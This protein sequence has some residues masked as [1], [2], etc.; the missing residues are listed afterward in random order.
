[1]R[2]QWRMESSENSFKAGAREEVLACGAAVF[3]LM[4][5]LRKDRDAADDA[6]SLF[7]ERLWRTLPSFDWRCSVRTW[8]YHLAR[9]ASADVSRQA[10]RHGR[11][12]TTFGV[13]S[14]ARTAARPRSARSG[15]RRRWRPMYGGLPD[16]PAAPLGPVC[17]TAHIQTTPAT[18]R[19]T[20]ASPRHSCCNQ[21]AVAS[22]I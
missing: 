4:I 14:L 16:S 21:V 12:L 3:G 6:F 5:A 17:A 20:R 2:A 22:G 13:A 19:A 8:R 11:R 15:S 1:L 7:A 18:H 10:Q 9:S